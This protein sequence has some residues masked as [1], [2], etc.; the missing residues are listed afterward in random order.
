MDSKHPN[1]PHHW[2]CQH[3]SGHPRNAEQCIVRD[4]STRVPDGSGV[5]RTEIQNGG[6]YLAEHT[7]GVGITSIRE[8]KAPDS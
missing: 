1:Y 8:V 3:P 4:G 7:I 2:D 5:R 6:L